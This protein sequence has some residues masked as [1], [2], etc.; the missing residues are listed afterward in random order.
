VRA[1]GVPFR[2]PGA[3]IAPWLALAAISALLATLQPGEWLAVLLVAAAAVL[4][5]AVARL[6]RGPAVAESVGD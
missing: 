2:V 3:G 1:G 5:F 6:R 4:V